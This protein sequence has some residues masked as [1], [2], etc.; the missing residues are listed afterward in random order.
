MRQNIAEGVQIGNQGTNGYEWIYSLVVGLDSLRA[1]SNNEI[2]TN[3]FVDVATKLDENQRIEITPNEAD[4]I[5]QRTH[6]IRGLDLTLVQLLA[7]TYCR[8]YTPAINLLWKS[9]VMTSNSPEVISSAES[10]A[11]ILNFDTNGISNIERGAI[12]ASS[13]LLLQDEKPEWPGITREMWRNAL[14]LQKALNGKNV[15]VSPIELMKWVHI[16]D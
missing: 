5:A 16:K 11:R 14:L 15:C 10:T 8:E 7:P 2:R 6:T 3:A 1:C 13:R 12:I 4:K 9:I